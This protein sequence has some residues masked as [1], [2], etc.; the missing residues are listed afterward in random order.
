MDQHGHV[1]LNIA[2]VSPTHHR[3]TDSRTSP[4]HFY[5]GCVGRTQARLI[6]SLSHHGNLAVNAWLGNSRGAAVTIGSGAAD[7]ASDRI[8]V[9]DRIVQALDV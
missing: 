2:S 5:I 4:M 1:F 8:P 6:V 9:A 7:D 3:I